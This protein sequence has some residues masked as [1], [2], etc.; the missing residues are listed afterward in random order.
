M[1]NL[2][3]V[4]FFSVMP[5]FLVAQ[6]GEVNSSVLR[7]DTQNK[8]KVIT[9]KSL[10]RNKIQYKNGDVYEGEFVKGKRQG[11]AL[12]SSQMARNILGNGFKTNSMVE[13]FLH[14][15][16]EMCMMVFGIRIISRG[17]ELCVIIMVMCMMGNG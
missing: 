8:E 1:K 13:A 7:K 6:N 5:S 10:E 17:M 9:G 16:M 14:L 15:S 11:K 12:I 3:I 2:Y 4:I